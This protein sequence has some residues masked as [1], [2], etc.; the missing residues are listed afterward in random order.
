[1][2]STPLLFPSVFVL[3][4]LTLQTGCSQ[5]EKKAEK[6]QAKATDYIVMLDVSLSMNDPEWNPALSYAKNALIDWMNYVWL[7]NSNRVHNP[8]RLYLYPFAEEVKPRRTFELTSS[9]SKE[10]EGYLNRLDANGFG[11]AIITS[12]TE[13]LETMSKSGRT[14]KRHY[15]LITDGDETELSEQLT[16]SLWKN[17]LAQWKTDMV[18]DQRNDQL[19]IMVIGNGSTG[20]NFYSFREI[21]EYAMNHVDPVVTVLVGNVIVD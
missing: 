16:N 18:A 11:S 15:I 5:A 7:P 2:R 6:N 8:G 3:L 20:V 1:M 14:A 9:G 12:L 21:M 10:F 4:A 13:V 17:K 19:L